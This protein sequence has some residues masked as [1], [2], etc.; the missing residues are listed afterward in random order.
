MRKNIMKSILKV[1]LFGTMIFALLSTIY[2]MK[3]DAADFVKRAV[4]VRSERGYDYAK[5][6]DYTGVEGSRKIL[7]SHYSV[8]CCAHGVSVA[9]SN[10]DDPIRIFTMNG[11]NTPGDDEDDGGTDVDDITN[12]ELAIPIS[13]AKKVLNGE[14]VKQYTNSPRTIFT[15]EEQL[16]KAEKPAGYSVEGNGEAADDYLESWIIANID[17]RN[18]DHNGSPMQEAWWC[19]PTGHQ[20]K[21]GEKNKYYR[22]AVAFE[23]YIKSVSDGTYRKQPYY[24]EF[25]GYNINPPS[26]KDTKPVV[27]YHPEG[28]GEKAFYLIGPYA[29]EGYKYMNDGDDGLGVDFCK[30]SSIQVKTDKTDRYI[31]AK[32][33]KTDNDGDRNLLIVSKEID[34]NGNEI[35]L[36]DVNMPDDGKNFYI[37][38]YDDGVFKDSTSIRDIKIEFRYVNAWAYFNVLVGDKRLYEFHEVVTYDNILGLWSHELK[39]VRKGQGAQSQPLTS[40]ARGLY[41]FEFYELHRGIELNTTKI[42]IIKKVVDSNGNVIDSKNLDEDRFDFTLKV[43]G[44]SSKETNP[45]EQTITLTTKNPSAESSVYYW[46]GNDEIIGIRE[47][48]KKEKDQIT[49]EAKAR[50]DEIDAQAEKDKEGKSQT[51]IDQIVK[52]ANT[53]KVNIDNEAEDKKA[54]IDKKAEDEISNLEVKKPTFTLKEKEREGNTHKYRLAKVEK[55][56]GDKTVKVDE[57]GVISGVMDNQTVNLYVY[58]EISPQQGYIKVKKTVEK[59][60]AGVLGNTS[61]E[62]RTFLFNVT[63][64][65]DFYY[66]NID[67]QIVHY[68]GDGKLIVNDFPVTVNKDT[69]EGEANFNDANTPIYWYGDAP[70]VYIEEVKS[71]NY[72]SAEELTDANKKYAKSAKLIGTAV[73][74]D[75]TGAMSFEVVD[76]ENVTNL[77]KLTFKNKEITH[78][79]AKIKIIK[80]VDITGKDEK[81]VSLMLSAIK[82]LK[83]N[84]QIDVI[85]GETITTLENAFVLDGASAVISEDKDEGK[86]YIEITKTYDKDI[87]WIG[88]TPP[89]YRITEVN[90]PPGTEFV[91]ATTTE[92]KTEGESKHSVRGTLKEESE[93]VKTIDNIIINK[94]HEHRGII[95]LSKIFGTLTDKESKEKINEAINHGGTLLFNVDIEGEFLYGDDASAVITDTD[96]NRNIRLIGKVEGD[97]YV[98]TN[99]ILLQPDGKPDP[100]ISEDTEKALVMTPTVTFEAEE[101]G[102]IT[103]ATYTNNKAKTQEII[104]YGENAPSYKI[105]ED[106][107]KLGVDVIIPRDVEGKF[108]TIDQDTV[109]PV[110]EDVVFNNTINKPDLRYANLIIKKKLLGVDG[111][112][113]GDY[114]DKNYTFRF[115]VNVHRTAIDGTELAQLPGE[116]DRIIDITGVKVGENSMEWVWNGEDSNDLIYWD[117]VKEKEPYITVDE[118]LSGAEYNLPEGVTFDSANVLVGSGETPEVDAEYNYYGKVDDKVVHL[119][120]AKEEESTDPDDNKIPLKDLK[121]AKKVFTVEC[122]FNNKLN[123]PNTTT[124]R[125]NIIKKLAGSDPDSMLTTDTDDKPFKFRVTITAEHDFEYLSHTY[126]AGTYYLDEEGIVAATPESAN[127]A[128]VVIRVKDKESKT[129]NWT[130][131]EFIWNNSAEGKLDYDVEEKDVAED[132][133][134]IT[135]KSGSLK[136][137]ANIDVECTN[138]KNIE[139]GKVKIIKTVSTDSITE[140]RAKGY[141]FS[142]NINVDGYTAPI[143]VTLDKDSLSVVG[144]NYTWQKEIDGIVLK[145]GK[146]TTAQIQEVNVPEGF[147]FK[148]F[149]ENEGPNSKTITLTPG[150]ST[151]EVTCTNEYVEP[152]I[153]KGKIDIHKEVTSDTLKKDTDTFEFTVDLK[154]A[155][156][157]SSDG[158][159]APGANYVTSNSHTVVLKAGETKSINVE[160]PEGVSSPEYEVKENV[161]EDAT[162]EVKN[163]SNS[164][165]TVPGTLLAANVAPSTTVTVNAVNGPKEEGGYIKFRKAVIANDTFGNNSL[166]DLKTDGE[167]TFKVEVSYDGGKTRETIATP[168]IKQNEVWVSQRITWDKSGE[169]PIYYITELNVKEGYTVEGE[170]NGNPVP[171]AETPESVNEGEVVTITNKI[172]VKH[173]KFQVKK[174]I[175]ADLKILDLVDMPEFKFKA[176][177]KGKFYYDNKYYDS[178]A[179]EN[180]ELVIN[181]IVLKPTE[182]KGIYTTYELPN[183][184]YWATETAPTVFIEEVNVKEPWRCE[185]ISNGGK[186]GASLISNSTIEFEAINKLLCIDEKVFKVDIGGTVWEDEEYLNDKNNP[187][188]KDGIMDSNENRIE[189]V[190]VYIY[191]NDQLADLRDTTGVAIQQPI[192]TDSK[193]NWKAEGISLPT[194]AYNKYHVEFAYDGQTYEPTKFLASYGNM[195][196]SEKSK[197]YMN[198][199]THRETYINDSMAIDKNRDE[200]NDRINEIYGYSAITGDGKTVGEVKSTTGVTN[201]INYQ[202]NI[203]DLDAFGQ[204]DNKIESLKSKL[205]TRDSSG[206]IYDVFKAV[207]STNTGEAQLVYPVKGPYTISKQPKIVEERDFVDENQQTQTI[208][209]VVSRTEYVAT[210]TYMK[211]INLG[212]VRRPDVGL[213]TTKK[214]TSAN[215]VSRNG[216]VHYEFKKL[217]D[218]I[219]DSGVIKRQFRGADVNED[220]YTYG[221]EQMSLY[222]PDYYYREEVYSSDPNYSLYADKV[223]GTEMQVYLNYVLTVVNESSEYQ[224][225]INSINDYFDNSLEIVNE[226]IKIPDNI[227]SNRIVDDSGRTIDNPS[228]NISETSNYT[229]GKNSD[230]VSWQYSGGDIKGSDGNYYSKVT[231]NFGDKCILTP[232]GDTLSNDDT[233]KL[234]INVTLRVKRERLAVISKVDNT[235]KVL[236]MVM[237]IATGNKSNVVE[238]ANYSTIDNDT[239]KNAGKIDSDSAADNVNIANYNE[240]YWYEDD[241]YAAPRLEI[242]IDSNSNKTIEGKAWED[243]AVKKENAGLGVNDADEARIGGL[244]TELPEKITVGTKVVD[245]L[246]P[247]NKPMSSLGGLTYE[248]VTGFDSTTETSRVK[249]GSREVGSY[250]FVGMPSGDYITRFVY[251]NDKTKLEDKNNNTGSAIALTENGELF[252]KIIANGTNADGYTASIPL[253]SAYTLTANYTA[254]DKDNTPAVYNGQDYK[255]TIYRVDN[256]ADGEN[257]NDARDNEDRRLKVMAKS[258]TITNYN[259][260]VLGQANVAGGHHDELYRDYEMTADTDVTSFKAASVAE[261]KNIDVGLVERP[262]NDIILDKEINAIKIT[263]NDNKTIFDAEYNIDY[264]IGGNVGKGSEKVLSKFMRNGEP[265]YLMAVVT[266]DKVRS[267]NYDVMQE[268]NKQEDKRTDYK[269]KDGMDAIKNFRY[270]NVDEDILQGSTITLEYKFTAINV[271]E[272]DYTTKEIANLSSGYNDDRTKTQETVLYELA[273]KVK[274]EKSDT[275]S[276]YV[277][278]KVLGAFYY[279]GETEFENKAQVKSRIR[280]IVDYADM[281]A[282]FDATFNNTRDSSWRNALVSE[283]AGNGVS[284]DRLLSKNITKV[285]RMYDK[286]ERAYIE[287]SK[288]NIVLSMDVMEEKESELDNSG[289]EKELLPVAGEDGKLDINNSSDDENTF[290]SELFLVITRT[291]SSQDDANNLAFDNVSEIVKGM[292]TVG[293]RDI[294]VVSGNA[295][296]KFGEFTVAISER[297]SSATELVTFTPPTGI[298][299]NTNLMNQ[300]LIMTTVALMIVGAGVIIIKRAMKE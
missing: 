136:N 79:S 61:D 26:W 55:V 294:K 231:A 225:K 52:D 233:S 81:R 218:I 220:K 162:Y 33:S 213:M 271:G 124:S 164:K 156:F 90:V 174:S 59:K 214:L 238:V 292:N 148:G 269:L 158:E 245:Y 235:N 263:T 183:E 188:S 71:E 244:T 279:T 239:G 118:V 254:Q 259:S 146:D 176:T 276:G 246:W 63:V 46:D 168:T 25:T 16:L 222:A 191:E 101:N 93:T 173:G 266:L 247:T 281:D 204:S 230:K 111:L 299:V 287:D 179:S 38:M 293:R 108:K 223:N 264:I 119:V 265:K 29:F 49:K 131:E 72:V 35:I 193:G 21:L 274:E 152:K 258:T 297:D 114:A 270:I 178:T 166:N 275:T 155:S 207:A 98:V 228:F 202:A 44:A 203:A 185:G 87:T 89:D 139:T 145:D 221:K 260:E 128:E 224:V 68:S 18:V 14:T 32:K 268:L 192:Y 229:N 28:E 150:G 153:M 17:D 56:D 107:S 7:N 96:A 10:S 181:D 144:N 295:N 86:K 42:N 132:A 115:K 69:L 184:I 278:G 289:F 285:N 236:G 95:E 291:V 80:R 157:K 133:H 100:T 70:T 296:P 54:K 82:K 92:P 210:G 206:K 180:K 149:G 78:K 64:S 169:R 197:E 216:I 57:N 48:A 3:S 261:A 137:A 190:E 126:S 282:V 39:A 22:S 272:E 242:S 9:H 13:N 141:V 283:L 31:E 51:E 24:D 140:E 91:S 165:G 4:F 122:N 130:S 182:T 6:P 227:D 27:S 290:A 67:N 199:S 106:V 186:T 99:Y 219:N 167:F 147:R 212:L 273:Q 226:Q 113:I 232:K 250:K 37:K 240:K 50:K 36:Q 249:D 43:D 60:D 253:G 120:K 187:K 112:K 83:F 267:V 53:K 15:A 97:N 215:I 77:S 85:E 102:N 135:N 2:P 171:V 84:F 175:I 8:M 241:T 298:D 217:T 125:L 74:I 248:D 172:D 75:Q 234:D 105:N 134:T 34:A 12:P 11:T 19:T 62:N 262:R 201:K 277:P 20:G 129:N 200:V 117:P 300:V 255:T 280:Q 194:I 163:I 73:S 123:G 47:K 1:S 40:S 170:V 208:P 76:K 211:H 127:S 45:T 237:S 195:R 23:K 252:N 58:N 198:Q 154:G 177:I 256:K 286:D 284:K 209:V 116:I 143:Q 103:N 159:I 288:N 30:V 94:I 142:F 243:N 65:G 251:G 109:E 110:K 138:G 41:W 189:N 257:N 151:V 104:W 160:W 66:R 88:N 121:D 205:Q 5:Y 161:P 196:N